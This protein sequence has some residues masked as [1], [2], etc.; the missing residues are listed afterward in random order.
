VAELA[1]GRAVA[2]RLEG[3]D[4]VGRPRPED[5][6]Q[7]LDR[8]QHARHTPECER[9]RTEPDDLPIVAPLESPHHLNGIGG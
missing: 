1:K 5:S 8:L 3:P 2:L 4:V 7:P 6:E 9:R